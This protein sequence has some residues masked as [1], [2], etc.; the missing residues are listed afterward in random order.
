MKHTAQKTLLACRC[1]YKM[2]KF[3]F[4]FWVELMVEVQNP[5]WKTEWFRCDINGNSV[6]VWLG[7]QFEINLLSEY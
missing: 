2:I 3:F 1:A 6:V 5:L 4:T 7:K